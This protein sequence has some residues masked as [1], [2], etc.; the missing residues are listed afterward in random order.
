MRSLRQL[1]EPRGAAAVE[2][3]LVTPI[4][5]LMLYGVM[6]VGLLL[7]TQASLYHGVQMAARCSAIGRPE[8]ASTEQTKS[9]AAQQSFSLNPPS[10]TFAV[11]TPSCG[12]Q[13]TASYNYVAFSALTNQLT[14]TL[15]ARSC[16]LNQ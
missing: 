4:F 13:V 16:F 1:D 11:T 8:C 12:T 9:Y 7:W 3:A 5:L 10:S 2:T 6:Q 15:S 14:M